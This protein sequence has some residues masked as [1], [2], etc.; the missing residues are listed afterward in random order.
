M[1]SRKV[2]TDQELWDIT[3]H[4]TNQAPQYATKEHQQSLWRALHARQEQ[5]GGLSDKDIEDVRDYFLVWRA[6]PIRRRLEN[7]KGDA[8]LA[9]GRWVL[10]WYMMEIAEDLGIISDELASPENFTVFV[11]AFARGYKGAVVTSVW[12]KARMSSMGHRMNLGAY[13]SLTSSMRSP[14]P[15][16]H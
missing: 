8:D 1:S 16:R 2:H 15:L 9:E 12:A 4:L 5:E 7:Q 11:N 10:F 13:S 3:F 14:K 6:P